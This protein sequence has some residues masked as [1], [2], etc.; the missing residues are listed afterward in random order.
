MRDFTLTAYKEYLQAIKSS[1]KIILRF[2]EYLL[3]QPKPESF[4]LIRHDVDR[5]PQNALIMSELENEAGIKTTYYFRAKSHTFK[6]GIIK[7]IASLEHE[8]GYHYE[9]LSDTN[10]DMSLA[11]KDFEN[12]LKKFREIAPTKT[13]SMHGR[14]IICYNNLDL[15]RNNDNQRLLFEKYGILGEAYLD[16]DYTNIAYINDTGRNWTSDESNKRDKVIS[17]IKIDFGN[18]R[19]LLKCMNSS[20]YPKMVFQIHPER[21]ESAII[22][23]GLQLLKDAIMNAVKYASVKFCSANRAGVKR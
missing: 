7:K 10:G 13:I 3:A 5:K 12:N 20:P 9:S 22:P 16:I 21:W 18:R 4:C 19:I 14:P 11:L 6:P 17:N 2:D 23:W 15:W 1:Y 8:I